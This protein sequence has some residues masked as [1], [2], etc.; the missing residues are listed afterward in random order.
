MIDGAGGGGRAH[1]VAVQVKQFLVPLLP[2]VPL[3][4]WQ[5]FLMRAVQDRGR[6][7]MSQ[8]GAITLGRV[9]E[10]I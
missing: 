10:A 5:D 3:L 6:V 7:R 8:G 2:N 4:F 9:S 1:A